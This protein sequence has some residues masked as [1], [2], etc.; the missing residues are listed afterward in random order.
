MQ[1]NNAFAQLPSSSLTQIPLFNPSYVRES[2]MDSVEK[3]SAF[4]R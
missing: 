1:E 3:N 4:N 2:D